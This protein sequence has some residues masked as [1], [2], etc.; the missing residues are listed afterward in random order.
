MPVYEKSS[1]ELMKDFFKSIGLEGEK[2]FKRQ[3]LFNWFNKNYPKLKKSHL[4]SELLKLS[5]NYPSRRFFNLR[6]NGAD[7]ILFR[8]DTETFRFCTTEERGNSE[9]P[10]VIPPDGEEGQEFALEK[11]LQ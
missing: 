9:A 1:S 4:S 3:E 7:D 2:S 10:L 11:H 8:I 5:V 6:T